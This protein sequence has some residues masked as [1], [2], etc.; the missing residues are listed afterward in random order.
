M[1]NGKTIHYYVRLLH[2]YVGFFV[3][4]LTVIYSISGVIM[5]YRNTDF[6][7]SEVQ[8]EKTIDLNL[9]AIELRQ[10]LHIKN[11]KITDENEK[12][13]N[14]KIKKYRGTYDK[15]SGFV[16]YTNNQ[17]PF[18]LEKFS[19]LHKSK[20]EG[21]LHWFTTIYGILL[22]FLAVSAFWMFKPSVKTYRR[23]VMT[24]IAG[25]IFAIGLLSL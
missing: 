21:N 22:L 8:V 5:I 7:K 11:L 15:T 25:A 23:G 20:V 1:N 13:V 19:S 9:S 12:L 4:G 10:K 16:S 6:L 3:I 2:R 24:S 14:F 18:L 17:L